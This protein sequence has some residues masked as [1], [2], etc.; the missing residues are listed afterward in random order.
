MRFHEGAEARWLAARIAPEQ[1]QIFDSQGHNILHRAVL[2]LHA[3]VVDELMRK[4]PR[5]AK[6]RSETSQGWVPLHFLANTP[7]RRDTVDVM[8]LIA[9]TRQ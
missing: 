3:E 2:G 5:L 6:V 9:R 8:M 7:F 4:F 1:T